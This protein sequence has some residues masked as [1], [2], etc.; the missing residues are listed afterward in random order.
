M[1]GSVSDSYD[2]EFGTEE[3]SFDVAEAIRDAENSITDAIGS[4]VLKNI[5]SVVH[6]SEGKKITVTFSEKKWR[7]IRFALNMALETL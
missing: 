7:V 4:D 5:V 2:P 3:N 1:P 6:G